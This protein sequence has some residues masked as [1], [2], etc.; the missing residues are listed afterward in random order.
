MLQGRHIGIQFVAFV[1]ILA[2][3]Y[4]LHVE[5]NLE[6]HRVLPPMAAFESWAK[7][8]FKGSAPK[9]KSTYKAMCDFDSASLGLSGSCSKVFESSYGHILSH[10]GLVPK[11]H[12]LDLSLASSGELTNGLRV[13]VVAN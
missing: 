13:F 10:W 12:M 1:G 4:A 5:K 8:D 3:A 9:G 2:A 6:K 11:G 7:H